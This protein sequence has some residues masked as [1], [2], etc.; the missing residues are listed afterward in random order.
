MP[1]PEV[2]GGLLDTLSLDA[3]VAACHRLHYLR[4]HL[5]DELA[6]REW[7]EV[8]NHL[9]R[10]LGLTGEAA[11][12]AAHLLTS[13]FGHHRS[14]V[15][16]G[17]PQILRGLQGSGKALG[18]VSNSDGTL[19]ARLAEDGLYSDARSC[20]SPIAF[21]VDSTVVGVA[22]PSS[23]IF[24]VAIERLAALGVDHQ[25]CVFV[26]DTVANDVLPA[27]QTG[28]IPIHLNPYAFCDG[29]DHRHISSLAEL[30]SG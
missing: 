8:D 27:A 13:T 19:A 14:V 3:S 23:R 2:I 22:K 29:L 12:H 24:G 10:H 28:F 21:V 11:Q 16:P 5:Y 30:T 6:P 17:V 25:R 9:V 26:G 1:D 20:G 18:V 7:A 15:G 4:V